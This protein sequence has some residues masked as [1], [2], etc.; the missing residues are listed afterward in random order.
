M[1]FVFHI[2]YYLS[3]SHEDHL[4]KMTFAD[5]IWK[6]RSKQWSKKETEAGIT[7]MHLVL[8]GL[9][10]FCCVSVEGKFAWR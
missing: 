6:W 10:V 4:S 7:P 2:H 9:A 3:G 5:K 8:N 1:S